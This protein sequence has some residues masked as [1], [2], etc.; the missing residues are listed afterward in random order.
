MTSGRGRTR[1]HLPPAHARFAVALSEVVE[2]AGLAQYRLA[3]KSSVSPTTL[4]GYLCGHRLPQTGDTVDRLYTTAERHAQLARRSLPCSRDRLREL[5]RLAQLER[6]QAG[7][8]AGTAPERPSPVAPEQP[9]SRPVAA[10]RRLQRRVRMYGMRQRT[11]RPTARATVPVPPEK[12]DRH[13]APAQDTAPWAAEAEEVRRHFAEGREWDAYL[14]LRNAAS[15]VPAHEFPG[16]VSSCRA[17]GLEQAVETLL[18]TAAEREI[19]AVLTI[20]AALHE[21]RQ[22]E[23]AGVMLTAARGSI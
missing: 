4:S 17:A 18:K 5:L 12:G 19:R 2:S 20:T 9:A 16:V 3:D 8:G 6:W 11:P 22:Y 14:M 15:T 21:Q 10:R 13:R 23:D 7:A 1:P